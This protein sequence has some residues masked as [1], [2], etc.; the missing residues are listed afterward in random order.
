MSG[1][2]FRDLGIPAPDV[3]LEVGSASHAAQTGGS[4]SG[5]KSY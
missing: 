1:G 5:S 2:F 3:N 4:W